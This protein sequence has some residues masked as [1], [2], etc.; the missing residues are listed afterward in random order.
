MIAKRNSL[1]TLIE[2]LELALDACLRAL[3]M[4]MTH[5]EDIDPYLRSEDEE[6]E[7]FDGEKVRRI[8]TYVSTNRKEISISHCYSKEKHPKGLE[9]CLIET[10]EM[11]AN[12]GLSERKHIVTQNATVMGQVGYEA[13][14]EVKRL[15]KELTT[16]RKIIKEFQI[17]STTLVELKKQAS[18]HVGWEL[19]KNSLKEM[20]ETI[21][22]FASQ[23]YE[24]IEEGVELKELKNKKSS[25]LEQ[26][27]GHLPFVTNL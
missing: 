14:Q 5:D 4:G 13:K 26:M 20:M 23:I 6:E 11:P 9:D 2:H 17:V 25:L 24:L 27:D 1:L 19:M 18:F 12:L 7:L 10:F 3:S 16:N 8:D 15:K 21:E 22:K